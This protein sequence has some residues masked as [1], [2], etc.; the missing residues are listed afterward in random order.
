MTPTMPRTGATQAVAAVAATV[1][2][3]ASAFPGIRAALTSFSPSD[4]AFLRFA[5]ATLAIGAYWVFMRPALP[6][7][8]DWPRIILAGGLGITAYN[9]LLNFGQTTVTAGA[10]SF[11]VNMNPVFALILGVTLAAERVSRWGVLGMLVSFVGVGVIAFGGSKELSFDWGAVYIVAAAFCFALSFVVQ[12]PL[13]ARLKPISVAMGM[14]WSATIMLLPVAP[15]ALEAL[16]SASIGATI[17]L[18]FLGLGPSM[19][20][21]VAWSYALSRYPVS[22]A[23]SFLYLVPPVALSVALFWVD[24]VP[25]LLTFVGGALTLTG[26]IVVNTLGRVSSAGKRA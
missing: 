24:E 18:I 1:V 26:V 22:Q 6:S 16:S 23:A 13:F 17:A 20:A 4:L 14:I 11:L 9:L 8:Q 2:L 21:Y 10:A 5:I 19:L 15:S 3:W 25:T 7:K 12:R